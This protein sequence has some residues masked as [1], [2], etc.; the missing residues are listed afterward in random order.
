MNMNSWKGSDYDLE[1]PEMRFL[2][3][4]FLFNSRTA[5]DS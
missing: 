1:G 3:F 2:G 5:C 4:L